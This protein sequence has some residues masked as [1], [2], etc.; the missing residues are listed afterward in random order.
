MTVVQIALFILQLSFVL[1]VFSLG[2]EAGLADAASLFHRPSLF[3]RSFFSMDFVM[4]VFAVFMAAILQLN[5][6]IEIALVFLAISPVPPILPRPLKLGG[7]SSYVGGL[8][9]STALLSIVLVP[10]AIE[11]L[12]KIFPQ[13]IH[14]SPAAVARIVAKTVLLPLAAGMLA[15]RLAPELAKKIGPPLSRIAFLLLLGAAIVPLSSFLPEVAAMLSNGTLLAIVVFVMVG[16]VVGHL[17]GGPDLAERSTLALATA[18]R[19]PGLAVAIA[20]VNFPGQQRNVAAVVLLYLVVKA[21]VLL[22]YNSW[23]KRQLLGYG[24]R[25]VIRPTQRAA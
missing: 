6:A 8:L 25:E 22:Q 20:G 5:P 4:P 17:L 12:S 24:Q 3:V 15:R 1:V 23:R 16:T 18:A 9:V 10:L 2:L 19:H 11:L 7:R 21:V 14:I 13:E